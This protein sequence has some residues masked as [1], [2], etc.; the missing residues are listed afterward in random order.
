MNRQEPFMKW[1]V[2]TFEDR[3]HCICE[4][5]AAFFTVALPDAF[6]DVSLAVLTRL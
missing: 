3:A 6:T 1:D 4:L 5:L 2:G